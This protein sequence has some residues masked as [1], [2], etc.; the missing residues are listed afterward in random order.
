MFQCFF[1]QSLKLFTD[2]RAS[3]KTKMEAFKRENTFE[4]EREKER[5]EKES[6]KKTYGPP[7]VSPFIFYD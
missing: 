3:C 2:D 6:Y 7:Y 5:K 1:V 4:T